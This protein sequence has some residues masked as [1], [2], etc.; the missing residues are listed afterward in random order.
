V[1][2]VGLHRNAA[3]LLA[4]ITLGVGLAACG[5]GASKAAS[6]A[7]CS[8]S[9]CPSPGAS[10][11]LEVIAV[12]WSG[13]IRAHGVPDFPDPTIGSNGLPNWTANPNDPNS[14]VDSPGFPAARRACQ[15]DLPHLGPQTSAQKAAANAQAL[16]YAT[17]MRASGVPDFPDPN[18][19]GLIQIQ[20]ATG[21]LEANSPQFEKADQACKSLDNGFAIQSSSAVSTPS[22]GGG[23]GS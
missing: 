13:C 3:L 2:G 9:G 4:L 23:S 16:K 21:S 19:Q 7:G 18:G 17:C 10:A 5:G 14:S 6:I 15:H 11:A 8:P 20:N 1:P 12:K 22:S